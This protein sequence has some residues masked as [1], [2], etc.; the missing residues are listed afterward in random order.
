[1]SKLI[2]FEQMSAE[3]LC[4]VLYPDLWPD[5]KDDDSI[6]G[7]FAAVA[8]LLNEASRRG[9]GGIL[10][11]RHFEK[12]AI[13]LAP[14]TI[15]DIRL[16]LDP[17]KPPFLIIRVA[18]SDYSS[19]SR[20]SL[21][22]VRARLDSKPKAA[23]SWLKNFWFH[24]WE[25]KPRHFLNLLAFPNTCHNGRGLHRTLTE[26][27]AQQALSRAIAIAAPARSGYAYYYREGNSW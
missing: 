11:K 27:G 15:S 14:E 3:E 1:M 10:A 17:K 7:A 19:A 13:I 20:R 22:H 23:N 26:D 18:V 21:E 25:Y 16:T 9:I 5:I 6:T 4:Q 2:Q 24:F 8:D 12:D